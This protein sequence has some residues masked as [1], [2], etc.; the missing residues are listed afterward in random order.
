MPGM[1]NQKD[2]E[3][4]IQKTQDFFRS[5]DL[6]ASQK[7]KPKGI[8]SPLKNVK[9]LKKTRQ[10]VRVKLQ[11][12]DA[13]SEQ[14]KTHSP[15]RALFDPFSPVY[16]PP[17][18]AKQQGFDLENKIK[19]KLPPPPALKI[20]SVESPIY[21]KERLEK[22][23][24][25]DHFVK[26]QSSEL[27]YK[28]F[29]SDDFETAWTLQSVLNTS[30]SHRIEKNTFEVIA[31]GES[32]DLEKIELQGASSQ[33]IF[34]SRSCLKPVTSRMVE[35][36]SY[37]SK[38]G[39]EIKIG[40]PSIEDDITF[41]ELVKKRN[42]MKRCALVIKKAVTIDPR[43][44]EQALSLSPSTLQQK[45]IKPTNL[46]PASSKE[47]LSTRIESALE[48][49]KA[50]EPVSKG[51]VVEANL[52]LRG[53]T[54]IPDCFREVML[55]HP[56]LSPRENIGIIHSKN[57]RTGLLTA[58]KKSESLVGLVVAY[59]DN[60]WNVT[61]DARGEF[62]SV[63]VIKNTLKFVRIFIKNDDVIIDSKKVED[64][65]SLIQ[66]CKF[67]QLARIIPFHN[68][69]GE[70]E[71]IERGFFNTNAGK[72]T[73]TRYKSG[74][75]KSKLARGKTSGSYV[76][77]YKGPKPEWEF[78][79]EGTE[80]VLSALEAFQESGEVGT[81]MGTP[82]QNDEEGKKAFNCMFT[83]CVGVNDLI[84][85]PINPATKV[86][87]LLVDNDAYNAET[88]QTLIET[89]DSFLIKGLKVKL[90]LPQGQ[91][92]GR[93][94]DFNDI[95]VSKGT[96][97]VAKILTDAVEVKKKEEIS[98]PTTLL[99]LQLHLLRCEKELA[100]KPGQ[101]AALHINMGNALFNVRKYVQAHS[102]YKKTL[103]LLDRGEFSDQVLYGRAQL[104]LG[105]IYLIQKKYQQALEQLEDCLEI[106]FQ[107]PSS[108]ELDGAE[109]SRLM[110]EVY[111]GLRDYKMA[112]T[113]CLEAIK[114][115]QRESRE[116]STIA[117]IH[118][119]FGQ[120]HGQTKNLYQAV[121][122]FKKAVY[123][124]RKFSHS[125]IGDLALAETYKK[126]GFA[127]QKKHSLR[128]A[129]HYYEMAVSIRQKHFCSERFGEDRG[130]T[131]KIAEANLGSGYIETAIYHFS[132]V[133]QNVESP[134]SSL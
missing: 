36:A 7:N 19:V 5:L 2:R 112:K 96:E 85:M 82:F 11:Q 42:G 87:V 52:R 131:L 38:K 119:L 123:F 26:L 9:N 12:V 13:P 127:F 89:V 54:K 16:A 84:K 43:L 67:R 53:I 91:H 17:A 24:H 45:I 117:D 71:G 74:R 104:G 118:E 22:Q 28:T 30:T 68:A 50:S 25:Q 10:V 78:R 8:S 125:E 101:D 93:K 83:S 133:L 79:G 44:M 57:S 41:D 1:L 58:M 72:L 70:I 34:I 94:I 130:L 4:V 14:T 46:A 6:S 121:T 35:I 103:T 116:D 97:G 92:V 37:F 80:N 113:Y 69:N 114:R 115:Y 128:D 60:F 120:I 3:S 75:L 134:S 77:F 76:C 95:L 15:P 64:P 21:A 51:G 59:K 99:E 102:H 132:H 47:S 86:I 88:H 62:G 98:P 105:K 65:D 81:A 29:I 110:G 56:D 31:I 66:V 108:P 55:K 23:F 107:Y 129:L 109:I 73:S 33:I 63:I 39:L 20:E 126:L 27:A 32:A 111:V 100:K 122:E 49:Y 48:I 90:A 61:A 106:Q 18:P 124:R 40:V